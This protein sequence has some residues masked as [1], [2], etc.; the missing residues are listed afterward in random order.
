MMLRSLLSVFLSNKSLSE[1][2]QNALQLSRE[3]IASIM[4]EV[5]NWERFAPTC[6]HQS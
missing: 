6:P 4:N 3:R 5:S 1:T 2:F